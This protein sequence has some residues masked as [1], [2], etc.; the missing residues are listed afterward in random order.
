MNAS[1]NDEAVQ[2][3]SFDFAAR[4]VLPPAT[5]QIRSETRCTVRDLARTPIWTCSKLDKRLSNAGLHVSSKC[6]LQPP[7]NLFCGVSR[8]IFAERRKLAN[9][10][11]L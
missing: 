11:D 10:I 1:S 8:E 3:G 9:T 7:E 4:N 6:A 5:G 2:V